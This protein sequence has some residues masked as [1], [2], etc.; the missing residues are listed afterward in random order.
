MTKLSCDYGGLDGTCA[1][2]DDSCAL[3]TSCADINLDQ[4]ICTQQDGCKFINI[5][6]EKECADLLECEN[7]VSTDGSIKIC[8]VSDGLCKEVAPEQLSHD[9]CFD[10]TLN[11]YHW[12]EEKCQSCEA[13]PQN[14]TIPTSLAFLLSGLT[15]ILF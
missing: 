6:L 7:I 11:T 9:Y 5:C 10:K 8:M 2:N 15:Y 14:I 3:V 13:A 1:F 12:I 4:E